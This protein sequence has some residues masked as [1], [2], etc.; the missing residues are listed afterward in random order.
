MS[1]FR[2]ELITTD[3]EADDGVALAAAIED[4]AAATP[5]QLT[6]IGIDISKRHVLSRS[7]LGTFVDVE[8]VA[9]LE[10]ALQAAVAENTDFTA[11]TEFSASE[12]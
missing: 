10:G 3:G 9:A 4:L 5:I 8:N 12:G 6:T 1:D 2:Y 7:D 11:I